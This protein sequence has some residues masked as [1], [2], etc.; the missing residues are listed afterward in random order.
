MGPWFQFLPRE[1]RIDITMMS[2]NILTVL[3][4]YE[5]FTDPK[6]IAIL[7]SSECGYLSLHNILRQFHPALMDVP[8]MYEIPK[9]KTIESL[10]NYVDSQDD[11]KGDLHK[12]MRRAYE[13][14][15]A[16]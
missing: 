9:C 3:Q 11:D 5:I 15:Y 2:G 8:S 13:Y 6:I 4:N 1:Y 16:E 14:I 12:F 10:A 7:R